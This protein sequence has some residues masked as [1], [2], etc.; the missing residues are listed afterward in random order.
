MN[1][2]PPIALFGEAGESGSALAHR[3]AQ[4]SHPIIVCEAA[5][6]RNRP[7]DGDVMVIAQKIASK[8]EGKHLHSVRRWVSAQ[9]QQG[10]IRMLRSRRT[11]R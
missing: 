2:L 11:M 5:K 8:A 9:V 4:A 7:D 3:R 1:H 10:A 6:G